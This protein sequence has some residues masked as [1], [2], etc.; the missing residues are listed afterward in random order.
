MSKQLDYYR[1]ILY[2]L[3]HDVGKPVIRFL[4]RYK[5]DIEK[6]AS[7]KKAKDILELFLGENI[8]NMFGKEHENISEAIVNHL[9]GTALGDNEKKSVNDAITEVDRFAASERGIQL[10]EELYQNVKK[11]WDEIEKRLGEKLDIPY[12]YS[13]YIVPMLSPLWVLVKT[14]YLGYVGIPAYLHCKAGKWSVDE[15]KRKFAEFFKGYMFLTKGMEKEFIESVVEIIKSLASEELWFPVRP[16]NLRTLLELK[17]LKFLEAVNQSSYADIVFDLINGLI[18]VK[19]IY[20][21]SIRR[22]AIDTVLDVLKNSTALVPSAIYW[23][24]LPD[25][26]LYS[27]SK[28]VAAYTACRQLNSKVR[29]LVIDANRIQK[30]ISSPVVAAAAS[31]VIRGRSLLVE[32]SLDSLS[33]YALELFGGLTR[34]NIIISEGGTLDLVIP[35]LPDIDARVAKLKRVAKELSKFLG[36]ELGFTVAVSEPFKIE[37]SR[38]HD[39]VT[40]ILEGKSADGGFWRVLEDTR[41]KL[42]VAKSL[43][44]LDEEDLESEG[45]V[46]REEDVV[47]FDAITSEP[48][49]RV[50]TGVSATGGHYALSVELN[51]KDYV[52]EIAGV[53]KIAIGEVLSTATHLSLVAGTTARG[54]LY[55]VGIHVYRKDQNGIPIP[56]EDTVLELVRKLCESLHGSSN[57]LYSSVIGTDVGIV[58]LEPSGSIYILISAPRGGGTIPLYDPQELMPI[59]I[60]YLLNV[61]NKLKKVLFEYISNKNGLDIYVDVEF[62][63]IPYI[64]M[65]MNDHLITSLKELIGKGIDVAIGTRFLGSYHPAWWVKETQEDVGKLV[66]AD[67]DPYEIIAVAKMDIDM[68]GKVREL[69]SLSPSR[70]VTLSD[71]VN[72]IVS[73][74]VYAY[75][76]DKQKSLAKI[77]KVLDV[78]PLYAGGDD[79]TI[80]GKW[81]Q[82][83]RY[84]VDVLKSIRDALK[85]LTASI[86]I[87]IDR[88]TAPILMLYSRAIEVLEKAKKVKASASIDI[89]AEHLSLFRCDGDVYKAVDVIP[90]E[91]P[92]KFYLMPSDVVSFYN[93]GVIANILDVFQ[94]SR[95]RILDKLTEFEEFKRDLYLLAEIGSE[96]LKTIRRSPDDRC[97]ALKE[98]ILY[99]DKML[100]LNILYSYTWA[101]RSEELNKLKDIL[102]KYNLDLLKYPDDIVGKT[103]ILEALRVLLSLKPIIDLVILALRRKEAVEP[104]D[105]VQT[106]S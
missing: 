83:I 95:D 25:I 6:D 60:E 15:A 26:S 24:L 99:P 50:G 73:G 4:W 72:A 63:N 52:D 12:E 65:S 27:H 103:D 56:A 87:A 9:L 57:R 85:P 14:D 93:L 84:I 44:G 51:I 97:R 33:N 90:L 98:F 47:G 66:L 89:E 37:Q 5:E 18:N 82:V 64:S 81:A 30:F 67:L 13:H 76:I 45:V 2:A 32:L 29:W 40:A 71:L 39:T 3:L 10:K 94:E 48:I 38:F 49:A 17:A 79:V 16:L 20:E 43:G 28:L 53:D 7:A 59:T 61:I 55:I 105:F 77:Q 31:R 96:V 104:S 19:N 68:F 23:S 36:S 86:G 92:S 34:A 101:R 78:I 54:L 41:Y 91:P 62:I 102:K 75:A 11:L 100:S 46:A 74:K 69:L 8:E 70:F 106:R 21:N 58:P 35:D 80:Y 88:S 1:L 22:G 42:A